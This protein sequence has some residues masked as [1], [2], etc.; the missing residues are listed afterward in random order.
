MHELDKGEPLTKT[1]NELTQ[2]RTASAEENEQLK[3]LRQELAQTQA[4]LNE[5]KELVNTLKMENKNLGIL[6]DLQSKRLKTYQDNAEP[7]PV[8]IH[9]CD[10]GSSIA[11]AGQ[12]QQL[13][14]TQLTNSKIDK[15]IRLS[16]LMLS[17]KTRNIR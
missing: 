4:A 15:L 1:Q 16:E 17:D 12:H 5:E 14:E 6:V 7:L 10:Q 9:P 8:S 13:E 11:N 2:E 3:Q